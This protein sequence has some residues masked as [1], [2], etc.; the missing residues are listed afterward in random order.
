MFQTPRVAFFR[1]KKFSPNCF[2]TL[3]RNKKSR[4]TWVPRL[5]CVASLKRDT[6]VPRTSQGKGLLSSR[7]MPTAFNNPPVLYS[8][9]YFRKGVIPLLRGI[10]VHLVVSGS[11]TFQ[12]LCCT[13][14]SGN[15]QN[16]LVPQW[17]PVLPGEPSR[18]HPLQTR[19]LD[20]PVKTFYSKGTICACFV[21]TVETFFEMR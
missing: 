5:I 3:S 10:Q 20:F 11:Y 15:G 2:M 19:Q 6:K 1:K 21:C 18:H 12:S 13:S 9:D 7:C 17:D 4:E 16:A 8:G 14:L